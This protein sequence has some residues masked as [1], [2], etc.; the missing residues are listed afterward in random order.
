M[1]D[2]LDCRELQCPMPIVKLSLAV[3]D[4]EPGEEIVVEATD[5]A[6][7]ADVHA[8]SEMTGHVIERFDRG[9]VQRASI[10]IQ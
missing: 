3:T 8:W 10:R 6:F 5:P 1:T 9:E 2:V 4:L 7:E